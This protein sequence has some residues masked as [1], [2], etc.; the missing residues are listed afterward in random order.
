MLGIFQNKIELCTPTITSG[1]VSDVFGGM[2]GNDLSD[3]INADTSE[4]DTTRSLEWS[5]NSNIK[6]NVERVSKDLESFYKTYGF[7]NIWFQIK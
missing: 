4:I 1:V 3:E 7:N 6:R 2:F 5:A